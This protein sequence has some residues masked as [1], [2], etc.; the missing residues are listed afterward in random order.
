MGS[1]ALCVLVLLVGPGR[2]AAQ[3]SA[4]RPVSAFADNHWPA[5]SETGS[6]TRPSPVYRLLPA[7]SRDLEPWMAS[8]DP[9]MD[10]PLRLGLD[11]QRSTGT[12]LTSDAFSLRAI[13]PASWAQPC[14]PQRLLWAD[15]G[16][17]ERRTAFAD[18]PMDAP[19]RL[20][21]LEQPETAIPRSAFLE[22]HRVLFSTLLLS[23]AIVAV[24]A[25]S[26][27]GY[28]KNH[29]F[30]VHPEGFFGKNT[31][32]GGADKAAHFADYFI[33]A[34]LFEDVYRMLGYS[35]NAAIMWGHGLAVATGLANEVSDGFTRHG[36]SWE[37]LL[38]D[39]GGATA[40]SVLSLTHT[41]DLFGF[42]TSHLP[43]ETYTKD[44]YSADFKLS[45]LGRRLGVNLGPLRWLLLS[46]TYGTK[47][48]RI[49]PPIPKERQL[50]FEIG[51]NLQQILF[52]VGVKRDTWWG[53]PLHLVAD[54]IRF[55]FTAVGFRV[56]LNTGKWSGPN[57]GNYD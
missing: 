57:N 32:N 1:L 10:A 23:T 51:L 16:E 9:G 48:Y 31:T 17:C 24:I 13:D 45:G 19:A 35:E 27:V 52:D 22:R 43:D 37:D 41:R 54:N 14:S 55:P 40:A 33:V 18:R 46:I 2:L 11:P 30:E 8:A 49:S 3:G 6:F 44:V 26:L 34:S 47:G 29:S 42:R 21:R 4:A 7:E 15:S 28:E 38:M 20:E 12:P 5:P 39:A 36:F 25:N 56:D 53:Y 50:G